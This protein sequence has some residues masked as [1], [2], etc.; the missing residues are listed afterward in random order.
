MLGVRRIGAAALGLI[1]IFA[2]G[3]A[4][5]RQRAEALDN[6]LART[7][8]MGWNGFNHFGRDVTAS[9]VE[10]EARVIV[11]SGMKA[12]GY[13]YVNLDGGWDLLQ[14]DAAGELQ[15]GPQQIP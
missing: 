3:G 15:A 14:R 8:P 13:S 1:V 2:L 11:S 5:T 6:G 7:P 9:I 10:A 12:A 4:S